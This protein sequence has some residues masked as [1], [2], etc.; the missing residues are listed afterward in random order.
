LFITDNDLDYFDKLKH[1]AISPINIFT[2]DYKATFS[3]ITSQCYIRQKATSLVEMKDY[4][5]VLLCRSDVSNFN[6]SNSDILNVA[7][8]KDLLIV[9]SGT[10]VHA[11]GGGGCTKCT[12]ESKCDLEFHA[13]DIC[14]Y[15]CMGSPAVMSVWNTFYDN[16]LKNYYDIQKTK[17]NV[18][19]TP[20]LH[21]IPKLEENEMLVSLPTNDW[22]LIENEV[23]CFYPEKL[24]RPAFKDIKILSATHDKQIWA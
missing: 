7:E 17:P 18:S 9:N 13:N 1:K 8:S 10:H 21:Y 24:M 23:H 11:G 6:I 5:V 22:A 19:S 20:Q 4:D 2:A 15:W 12:I 3:R 16:I 14:D